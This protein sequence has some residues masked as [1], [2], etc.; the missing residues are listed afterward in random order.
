M[1]KG[2]KWICV[3]NQKK[4]RC[5]RP[6]LKRKHLSIYFF[7]VEN[8]SILVQTP[9]GKNILYDVGTKSAAEDVHDRLDSLGV[10]KIHVMIASHAHSDHAGGISTLSKLRNPK[11]RLDKLYDSGEKNFKE[12]WFKD[13]VKFRKKLRKRY[14]A[15]KHEKKDIRIDKDVKISLYTD[16]N[17]KVKSASSRKYRSVWM[18]IKYKNATILFEGDSRSAYEKKML[19]DFPSIGPSHLLKLSEHGSKDSTKLILIQRV[20]PVFATACNKHH[21]NL[22]SKEVKK[23]L[24]KRPIFST[25]LKNSDIIVSTDGRLQRGNRVNYQVK[26]EKLGNSDHHR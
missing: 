11:I 26:F 23:R 13:Y 1:V 16:Y 5:S 12:V 8:E 25:N 24:G 20:Q 22:P 19:T 7:H 6:K 9:N 17:W 2:K 21:A 4:T 14:H 18:T 15:M 3:K 10:K